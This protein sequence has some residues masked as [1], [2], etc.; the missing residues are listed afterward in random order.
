MRMTFP[1]SV[2][3]YLRGHEIESQQMT[4]PNSDLKPQSG[5]AGFEVCGF[6]IFSPHYAY[7]ATQANKSD[8]DLPDLEA[9][10]RHLQRLTP[11]P[12]QGTRSTDKNRGP[13]SFVTPVTPPLQIIPQVNWDST[14]TSSS[15]TSISSTRTANDCFLGLLDN[16]PAMADTPIQKLKR[17]YVETTDDEMPAATPSKRNRHVK[18]ASGARPAAKPAPVKEPKLSPMEVRRIRRSIM[19]QMDWGILALDVA[20]NRRTV[21]YKT[22]VKAVLDKWV[23][24]VEGAAQK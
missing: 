24:K 7:Q 8:E 23:D 18:V 5:V 22:A 2:Q 17:A 21:V 4:P 9:E 6:A 19:E 15:L 10:I 16:V 3:A 11:T 1:P 13:A 14:S 20:S 12:A